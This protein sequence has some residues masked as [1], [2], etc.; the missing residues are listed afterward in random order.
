MKMLVDMGVAIDEPS[1]ADGMTPL[2]YACARGHV[3][4]VDMLLAHGADATRGNALGSDGGMKMTPLVYAAG[5][6]HVTVVKR[7]LKHPGVA[8]NEK[9][10]N[11][12]EC[13]LPLV[14]ACRNGH[15]AVAKSLLE[16]GHF[17]SIRPL[18]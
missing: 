15:A 17:L 7:L 2:M 13:C 11:G 12:V 10:A 14:L 6:G 3:E 9:N 1:M 8:L 5:A 16:V 18:P 4:V